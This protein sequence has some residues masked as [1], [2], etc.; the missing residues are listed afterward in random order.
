MHLKPTDVISDFFSEIINIQKVKES[1]E[2]NEISLF[3]RFMF[4]FI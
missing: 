4:N 2:S 1:N 3:F